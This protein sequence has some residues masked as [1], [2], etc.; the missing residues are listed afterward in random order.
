MGQIEWAMWAN[1]QALASG[2]SSGHA[3]L[4]PSAWDH[5]VLNQGGSAAGALVCLLE[6][7]RGRRRKG[8][9]MERC[10]QKYVAAAVKLFGPLT[11]NYYV[12]AVLHLLLSVPAGFL[13]ATIL[14]TVCL[15]IA[16]VIYLLAA[17]RG[18]QW[19]PIE[20][21]PKERPQAEDIKP[22]PSNPPPRPPAE[23]RKKPNE[24]EVAAGGNP[25][26]NPIP[27]TDEVV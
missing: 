8:S 20:S 14:G 16:S 11:R 23:A 9:T 3:L 19:L 12:R 17:I 1:E 25:Q 6:Y 15:A 7:P 21:K 18:E 4:F 2:L 26:V 13:L 22:P 5:L 10:G 27:V 24:D